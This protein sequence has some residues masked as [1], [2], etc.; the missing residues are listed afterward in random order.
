[1]RRTLRSTVLSV[2]NARST[3]INSKIQTIKK[4]ACGFPSFE[5]FKTAIFFHFGGFNCIQLPTENPDEPNF[6]SFLFTATAFWIGHNRYF[7]GYTQRPY[8]TNERTVAASCA[9]GR[10][11]LPIRP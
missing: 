7:P 10:I 3:S 2:R 5:D 1:M 9:F 4:A 8:R 11:D 6:L